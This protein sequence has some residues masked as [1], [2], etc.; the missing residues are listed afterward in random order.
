MKKETGGSAF[1]FARVS[2]GVVVDRSEGMTL[3]DYFA[4]HCPSPVADISTWKEEAE[5]RYEYADAMIA[6]RNKS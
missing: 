4:A 6:E 2:Q 3:R 5:Y 1:P